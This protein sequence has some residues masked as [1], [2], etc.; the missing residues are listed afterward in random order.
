MVQT[1]S[2]AYFYLSNPLKISSRRSIK[3]PDHWAAL[4]RALHMGE[5]TPYASGNLRGI[6]QHGCKKMA[7]SSQIVAIQV[8]LARGSQ[9]QL[10]RITA[11]SAPTGPRIIWLSKHE[12]F[13]SQFGDGLRTP[14]KRVSCPA[15]L[16]PHLSKHAVCIGACLKTVGD[17]RLTQ[18]Q[19]PARLCQSAFQV[20]II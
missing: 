20:P 9:V 16:L 10:G 7:S 19:H 8:S 11:I 17:Q 5:I 3:K 2:L 6:E 14:P 18:N 4:Q 1:K 12:L 15:R 13:K